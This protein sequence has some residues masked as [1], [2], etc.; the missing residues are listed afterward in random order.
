MTFRCHSKTIVKEYSK[1]ERNFSLL[2]Y[3]SLLQWFLCCH[4]LIFWRIINLKY[5]TKSLQISSKPLKRSLYCR[6]SLFVFQAPS[7]THVSKGCQPLVPGRDSPTQPIFYQVPPPRPP[8][9]GICCDSW[10]RQ[11]WRSSVKLWD[12]LR[13]K[14]TVL[15]LWFTFPE[16][17]YSLG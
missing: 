9:H 4:E 5:S 6:S 3:F 1:Y 17:C 12:K 7:A 2:A 13:R 8:F 16:I 10:K 11:L 14:N 15:S